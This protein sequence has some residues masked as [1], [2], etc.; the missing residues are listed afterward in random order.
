MRSYSH[1]HICS[2]VLVI[3]AGTLLLL[4]Q[5][6]ASESFLGRLSSRT[7]SQWYAVSNTSPFR[8]TLSTIRPFD[9]A[10]HSKTLGVADRLYVV[11]LPSRTDRREIMADLERA[12]DLEFTWH[13]ATDYHTKDVEV[14]L[15]RIRWWRNEN[16]VND[17]EPKADPSSF[18]FQ[19]A[20]DV[21]VLGP[22]LGLSGADLWPESVGKSLLPPLPQVPIPDTRPPNL[23]SYGE[24]GNLFGYTPLR[25]AQISCWYSHYSLM[26]KIAEGDDEVA[27]VFEDDID[28]EWDLERRLRRMWPA[29]PADWDMVMIGEC[30]AITPGSIRS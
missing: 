6:L 12:M 23:D 27:I 22:N 19:W 17:S 13:D 14:I 8:Q 5:R 18:V 20:D 7:A 9:T 4:S 21:D 11:S 3:C 26:R 16:R 28:M 24:A 1:R 15:E 2:G 29:L 30:V 10:P 25:P